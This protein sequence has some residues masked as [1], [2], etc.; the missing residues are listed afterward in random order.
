MLGSRGGGAA[1]IGVSRCRKRHAGRRREGRKEGEGGGK[2][3]V[4][5]PNPPREEMRDRERERERLR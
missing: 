5:S 1:Y 2:V 4:F 3:H